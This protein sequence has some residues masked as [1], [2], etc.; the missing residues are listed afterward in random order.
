LYLTFSRNNKVAG[1]KKTNFIILELKRL[2]IWY[3]QIESY[4][5]KNPPDEA[6]DRLKEIFGREGD[7]VRYQVIASIEDQVKLFMANLEKL[8]KVLTDINTLRAIVEKGK[9]D[10]EVR[11]GMERP[12]FMDVDDD[13]EE[14]IKPKRKTNKSKKEDND[15]PSAFDDD[16]FYVDPSIEED[17]TADVE[18]PEDDD[19]GDDSWLDFEES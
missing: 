9:E 8:P 14:D 1:K 3:K 15:E 11:G 17:P 10:V 18:S 19:P 7:V 4:M 5:E 2:D 16:S 13:E 12:G 6:K